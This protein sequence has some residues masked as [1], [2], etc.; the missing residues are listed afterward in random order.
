MDPPTNSERVLYG[1]LHCLTF[2]SGLVD[3]GSYVA[4]G[5]VFIANMTGNVVFP[6]FA[7]GGVP[8]LSIGRTA[9]ALSFAFA[10]GFV[11][12]KLDSPLGQRRGDIWLAA[13]FGV[14]TLLL[15]SARRSRGT[16]SLGEDSTCLLQFTG[17]SL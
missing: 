16:S 11:A 17:S 3:A 14:E 5:H 13:A 15:F 8:N 4:M 1:S 7:F 9:A 6:G 2:V 12:G 10:G